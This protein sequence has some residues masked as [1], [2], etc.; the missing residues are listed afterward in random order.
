MLC[1]ACSIELVQATQAAEASKIILHTSNVFLH[2]L[3]HC[4]PRA[5]CVRAGG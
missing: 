5:S 3:Q 1:S 2:S 4:S